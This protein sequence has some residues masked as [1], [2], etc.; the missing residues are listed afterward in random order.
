MNPQY[1]V[2]MS[3]VIEA[4]RMLVSCATRHMDQLPMMQDHLQRLIQELN[5]RF[6][7]ASAARINE[8]EAVKRSNDL[9]RRRVDRR[10]E[11][12]NIT[13]SRAWKEICQ[14]YGPS[15][16]QTELLSLAEVISMN[17][18]LKVDR[19]AKRRKEVLIKWYDEN[20]DEIRP[21]LDYVILEDVDG[22]QFVG[23]NR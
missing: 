12:F 11:G 6:R 10:L 17:L 22:N 5:R 14:R 23:P 7:P 18:S 3:R 1:P 15:L 21:F 13:N 16:N 9:E 2:A 19:E 20:F 4:E 8:Q